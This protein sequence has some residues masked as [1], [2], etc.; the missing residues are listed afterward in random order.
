VS[1]STFTIIG[2]NFSTA[3]IAYGLVSTAKSSICFDRNLCSADRVI[4][5]FALLSWNIIDFIYHIVNFLYFG[6]H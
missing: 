5:I 2:L 3:V 4:N 6:V 1:K